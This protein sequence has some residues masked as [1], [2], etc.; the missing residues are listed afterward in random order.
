MHSASL[1]ISVAPRERYFSAKAWA[2]RCLQ[3]PAI[4]VG[5][6]KTPGDRSLWHRWPTPQPTC[7]LD[8]GCSTLPWGAQDVERLA[9]ATLTMNNINRWTP[10]VYIPPMWTRQRPGLL[11]AASM[12]LLSSCGGSSSTAT[13]E[14]RREMTTT[15]EPTTTTTTTTEAPGS[16]WSFHV[17]TGEAWEY[18]VDVTI[19]FDIEFSKYVAKSPPGKARVS[20]S[21][22]GPE[23]QVVATSTIPGRK[24]P[25]LRPNT[26][27][28]AVFDP[29]LV[30]GPNQVSFYTP[31]G[32]GRSELTRV[33]SG[34]P[35]LNLLQCWLNGKT[36]TSEDMDEADVD[37]VLRG[38][39]G[40]EVFFYRLTLET[41]DS[42]QDPCEVRLY[43]NGEVRTAYFEA[44]HRYAQQYGRRPYCTVSQ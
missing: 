14:I 36:S 24:A 4:S 5:G 21:A 17:V 26:Q 22:T 12:I 29:A 18:D 41:A 43:P 42:T 3:K 1:R 37:A 25:E 33:T 10:C 28:F 11:L 7:P 27:R 35:P 38:L 15:T 30:A 31:G 9:L 16:R 44:D 40:Q 34:G 8:R 6:M 13:R 32:C 20:T 39:E 19:D 2:L 23:P